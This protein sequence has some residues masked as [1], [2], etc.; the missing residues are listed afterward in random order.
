M[1]SLSSVC[2]SV[3]VVLVALAR[4]RDDLMAGRRPAPLRARL[5]LERRAAAV[6]LEAAAVGALAGAVG[7]VGLDDDVAELG[8]EPGRAAEDHPV[9]DHAAT[10]AGPERE[11][12]EVLGGS[13]VDQFRLGE[14]GA[15]GVVV[16]EDRDAEAA[17]E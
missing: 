6:G 8:A 4:G 9:D 14:R 2:V 10:D 17:L 3:A 12:D 15:V 16:D 7:A 1:Q 13:V 5:A 11:D